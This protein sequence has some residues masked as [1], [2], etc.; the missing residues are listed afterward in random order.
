MWLTSSSV[1]GERA[2][3]HVRCS[4]DE[5]GEVTRATNDEGGVDTGGMG[6]CT[7]LV[8]CKYT[9]RTWTKYSLYT[10]LGTRSTFIIFQANFF[11]VFLVQEILSTFT[12]SQVM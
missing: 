1:R 7:G 2:D 9:A 12:V 10:D 5:T 3:V 4:G 6:W 11:A 8:H